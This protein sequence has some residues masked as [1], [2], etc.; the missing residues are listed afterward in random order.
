MNELVKFVSKMHTWIKSSKA[1][2]RAPGRAGGSQLEC[3]EQEV[4]CQKA[5]RAEKCK[6]GGQKTV[7]ERSYLKMIRLMNCGDT[8]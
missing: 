6:G 7:P 2:Q 3:A 4:C 1:R 8:V 5:A